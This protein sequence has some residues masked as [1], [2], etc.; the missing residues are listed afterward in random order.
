M[1]KTGEY[2]DLGTKG[3][4]NTIKGFLN[5]GGEKAASSG[6]S[7]VNAAKQAV[8]AVKTT[9]VDTATETGTALKN[10]LTTA[11]NNI[12]KQVVSSGNGIINAFTNIW[13][14]IKGG[15]QS[16]FGGS[17]EGGGIVS[18]VVNGFKAVGNLNVYRI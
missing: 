17:G 4:W 16:L 10:I 13:N 15:A 6:T 5:N 3:L 7:Y 9:L 18:T 12:T 1:F 14:T 8:N 2:K 11:N